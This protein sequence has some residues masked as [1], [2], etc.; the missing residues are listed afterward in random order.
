MYHLPLAMF[1][2]KEVV[3]TFSKKG[4]GEVDMGG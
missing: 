3:L 4:V 2:P 1:V